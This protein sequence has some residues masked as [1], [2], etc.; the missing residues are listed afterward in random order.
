[1]T[2]PSTPRR[3]TIL[4]VL[5]LCGF[6]TSFGAHIVA[7][8]LPAYAATVGAGAFTIGLL[9]AAYDFAELF[10]KPAAGFLADRHGMKLVL[11][12]G[13][14]VFIGGSLLFLV[15]RPSLLL[16]VRFVQGLGAAALSTVSIALVAR[17]F[18][19]GRGR[20]FGIYNA[21]K[22]SG[23]VVAPAI[24]G[25]LAAQVGFSAIFI[26]S[27]LIAGVALVLSFILPGDA[28]G[29]LDDD[30]DEPSLGE[31]LRLFVD[32]KLAPIYAAI[33]V[34]MFLVGILF[35]FLPVYL[36]SVGY[37]TT[38]SGILLTTATAAYLLV[39]PLAGLLADRADAR[40]TVIVG[41]IVA[42]GGILVMTFTTGIALVLVVIATGA[43]VGTVWTNSDAL[44]STSVSENRLG[45]GIGAAQS[46]KEFGDMVGP[47]TVGAL[48]QLF[49]VRVGFVA[50]GAL[51]LLA[52]PF[53]ARRAR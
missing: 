48:T 17:T 45:A 15:I 10:A 27:A 28:R 42:A 5:S 37:S 34:N 21:I 35:G 50:C 24:G 51:A 22:G 3:Y 7:T 32:R 16:I 29:E 26:A 23:Y 30:D 33:V 1:V 52:L 20:A 8:N 41:L 38:A 44:V 43:G 2:E 18:A 9:I 49:G 12:A 31:M 11:I 47:L 4:G 36:R 46:F 13:L 40:L 25:Y 14:P 6:V 19:T 39:Q 53:L